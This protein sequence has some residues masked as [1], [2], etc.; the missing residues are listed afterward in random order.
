MKIRF[1]GTGTSTG[2]P[3]MGCGCEVCTSLET[4]DKRL[5]CSVQ[6][7][8]DDTRIIID[9]TP[10][11]RQQVID[12]PFSKI[13]GLLITHEHYDHVGGVDD[14]RPF[15]RFGAIDI[16]AETKVQNAFFQRMP[17][18]F[19]ENRYAGVPDI[20]IHIIND[21]QPFFVKNVEIIPIRVMHLN[22]PILGFRIK[23]FAYLTDVKYSPDEELTKLTNLDVLVMSA[24]RKERHISHQTLDEAV[25]LAKKIGAKQ[26]YFTHMSHQIGLHKDVNKKLAASFS[27]AYD[28]LEVF[29]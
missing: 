23:N 7:E 26:T 22:L 15:C 19:G 3:E 21:L 18:C 4:E 12:L 9:C 13:D 20:N 24:L 14:L 16:F 6:V 17:Y 5:R 25:S 10:D 1:L 29:L 2:V 8:A 28:G 27:L 11:F